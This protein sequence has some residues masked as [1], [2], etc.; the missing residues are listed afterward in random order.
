MGRTSYQIALGSVCAGVDEA[1]LLISFAGL[2]SWEGYAN[3]N[4]QIN[5]T[6]IRFPLKLVSFQ[7]FVYF[8]VVTPSEYTTKFF[9]LSLLL[10]YTKFYLEE[11]RN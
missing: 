9:T 7:Y 4:N 10:L 3:I 6:L 5:I 2:V 1:F 8:T 11:L